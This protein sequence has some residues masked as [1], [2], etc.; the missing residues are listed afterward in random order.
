MNILF[1]GLSSIFT[2]RILPSVHA[3]ADIKHIDC[4]SLSKTK[5][6][7]LSP[8]ARNFYSDYE[9][10]LINSDAEIVYISVRNHE[11]ANLVKIAL[12]YNKHVIVDK[13]AV[14]KI[15][16]AEEIVRIADEKNK[17]ISEA[18]V[19]GYHPQLDL[20]RRVFKD[21]KEDPS[22]ISVHFSM[23]GFLNENFRYKKEFGGGA[24]FDLGPYAMSIGS[25]FFGEEPLSCLGTKHIGNGLEVETSFSI[26]LQ[27]PGGRTLMGYFGFETE[28]INSVAIFSKQMSI[29]F[30][31][32]FTIP[33]DFENEIKIRNKNKLSIEKAEQADI[34]KEY[35]MD[36][37]A[38][39]QNNEFQKFKFRFLRNARLLTTLRNKLN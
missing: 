13:P 7:F 23:P 34:F 16:D 22:H 4:A 29:N 15:E 20:V 8:K 19:Y 3:I 25:E 33:A 28:Y 2:N 36:V 38:G 6:S 32:V 24:I 37:I 14:T 31:R 35:L 26:L 5:D 12:H 18:L 30:E 10:A 21:N 17:C 9:S 39:I 1:L 11:H 27:F